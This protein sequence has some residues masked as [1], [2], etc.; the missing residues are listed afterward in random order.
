MK[1]ELHMERFHENGLK[2]LNSAVILKITPQG[3][4][5]G[6]EDG[7]KSRSWKFELSRTRNRFFKI[8][9]WEK[10]LNALYDNMYDHQA[11]ENSSLQ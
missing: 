1:N 4:N 7:I 3:R 9:V 5:S 6:L 2:N 10:I 8:K 11:T